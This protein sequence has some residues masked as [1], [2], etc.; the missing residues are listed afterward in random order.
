MELF[1]YKNPFLFRL[2]SWIEYLFFKCSLILALPTRIVFH[3][4]SPSG[5]KLDYGELLAMTSHYPTAPKPDLN[6]VKRQQRKWS[7]RIA[8]LAETFLCQKILETGSGRGFSALFLMEN[9]FNII[10]SDYTFTLLEEVKQARLPFVVCNSTESLPFPNDSIDLVYSIN[11]FEHFDPA[12]AAIDEMLRILRPGGVLFMTFSPLYNSAFGLHAN[13]RLGIPYSQFLFT[14]DTIQR[15]LDDH[16]DELI[17]TYD[18]GSDTTK[19]GP[20]IN[21]YSLRRYRELFRKRRDHLHI[22]AF[23]ERTNLSGLNVIRRNPGL[24]KSQVPD[25]AE[26]VI[27]GIKIVGQKDLTES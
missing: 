3:L 10:A 15:F 27:E 23:I 1:F 21:G 24:I 22:L 12:E 4:S 20:S 2:F 13:R 14:A 17:K 16:H 6:Q 9:K 5:G 25:F 8:R 26:L 18:A 19:V 11:A 7:N